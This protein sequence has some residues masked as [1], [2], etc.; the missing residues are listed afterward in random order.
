MSSLRPPREGSPRR[1]RKGSLVDPPKGCGA[2]RAKTSLRV[3]GGLEGRRAGAKTSAIRTPSVPPETRDARNN[4]LNAYQVS[5]GTCEGYRI[6]RTTQYRV[7]GD[8]VPPTGKKSIAS[9]ESRSKALRFSLT[10]PWT[11]PRSAFLPS[12]RRASSS[13]TIVWR[14]R[15]TWLVDAE[16]DLQRVKPIPPGP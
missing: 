15:E 1:N 14:V 11:R 3:R 12:T 13:W 2:D 16:S 10:H 7:F 4:S 9:V 8:C 5:P 6:R